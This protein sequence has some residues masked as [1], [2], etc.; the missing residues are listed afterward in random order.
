MLFAKLK[1]SL[2][3][4]SIY[5]FDFQEAYDRGLRGIILDIDNTLVPH[6]APADERACRL[7]D[8]LKKMGYRLL[9]LSNNHGP[10]AKSFADA[11]GV[12]YICDAGKPSRKGYE[13]AIRQMQLGKEQV[14]CIG[15]QLLTDIW[16]ASNAGLQ[17]LLVEP[18]DPATD[19]AW[20]KVKRVMEKPIKLL[21]NRK[22]TSKITQD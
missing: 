22:G 17:S 5:E 1:P 14:L 10:R 3:A 15:D 21:H 7:A 9:I 11:V 6:D 20:I 18:V 12:P 19:T 4:E 8:R 13:Q 2:K 16:G